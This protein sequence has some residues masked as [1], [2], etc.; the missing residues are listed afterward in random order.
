MK[1]VVV[2]QARTNSSRLPGK[3][4]LPING[5]PVAV[6]AALRAANKGRQVILATSVEQSDDG[7]VSIFEKF[8]LK[9]FRGSLDNVLDRFIGAL[10]SWDDDTIV[11]RITG[12]NLFPDGAFIEEVE[13]EFLEKK[14]N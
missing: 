6:L 11:F 8:G 3:V 4:L 13:N 12:D 14:I 5:Y 2:L 7:L 9:Y 1:S 10:T